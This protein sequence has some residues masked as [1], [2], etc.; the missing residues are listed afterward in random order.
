[1]PAMNRL[2]QGTRT[3][4][5][6]AVLLDALGTIVRLEPPWP[7]LA[8]L[9]GIRSDSEVERAMRAEMAYY[10][11]HSGEGRDPDSLADL[12]RRCAA[13]LSR[14]LGREVTVETM[15]ASIR[16]HAFDDARPALAAL[17]ARG[18]TL[19]CVSNWDVSLPR[20]LERCGLADHLDGVLTSAAVGARKPDPAIFEAALEL[21]RCRADEAVHVGDTA[22]DDVAGARAAGIRALLLDR[23]GGGDLESLAQLPP[24]LE[25]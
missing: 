1:M 11:D 10:R 17:R 3:G 5:L 24:L 23:D 16:F 19:I 8:R 21:A 25:A 20:V 2:K 15:M 4:P 22:A 18:L 13:V 14:Q 9:L 7:R 12:R 6:R